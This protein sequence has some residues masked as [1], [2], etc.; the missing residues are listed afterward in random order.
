MNIIPNSSKFCL[1]FSIK[2]KLRINEY[3]MRKIIFFLILK[4]FINNRQPTKVI[5][6]QKKKLK[7]FI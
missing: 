3:F 2:L 4:L 5:F 6:A 7:L 1:V